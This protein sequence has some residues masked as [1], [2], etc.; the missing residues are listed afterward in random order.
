MSVSRYVEE[1][2]R[3]DHD[4]ARLLERDMGDSR[5][6]GEASNSI[7][8]TWQISFK[9]IQT[10]T[11]A[12]ARLLSLM[13]LF[14]RQGIPESLLH[15]HYGQDDDREADF[16]DDIHTLANFSLVGMSADGREFD[17]HRL[18]QFSTIKWLELYNELE[19]WQTTYAA[20]MDKSYPVGRPENWPVCQALFPHAQT[21]MNNR[22]KDAKALEAWASVLFKAAWYVSEMG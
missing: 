2:R 17:M 7:I 16:D 18:V 5:R 1:V 4:R 22:P 11:P 6:D 14:D 19:L 3:S 10:N 21:V 15:G 12:A 20:L 9:Y 8:A 13:S